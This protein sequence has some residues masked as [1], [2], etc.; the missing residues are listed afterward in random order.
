MSKDTKSEVPQSEIA[1]AVSEAI[2]AAL[3][4]AV[5]AAVQTMAAVQQGQKDSQEAAMNAHRLTGE[6]CADCKQIL[7]R[8]CKQGEHAHKMLVVFPT[9]K[10][11]FKWF[12]G[13]RIN[14]VLYLSNGPNHYIPVPAESNI[15]HDIQKWEDNEDAQAHGR[16]AEH[17]SGTMGAG[18]ARTHNAQM[19]WR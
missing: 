13:V 5:A 9:Q 1:R 14:S 15:E 18:V 17:D 3:P 19:A 12:Q 7:P 16:E 11:N 6:K 2:A 4:A 8:G 10:R